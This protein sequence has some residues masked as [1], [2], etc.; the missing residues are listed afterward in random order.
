MIYTLDI[1]WLNITRYWTQFETKKAKTSFRLWIHKKTPHA[2][3]FRRNTWWRHQMEEFSASLALC[4]G[5]S[6]VTDE[7]SSQRPVTRSFDVFFDLPLNKRLSKHSWGWWFEAPSRSLCRHRCKVGCLF[8]IL[9]EGILRD[10]E[11]S[12]YSLR[13]KYQNRK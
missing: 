2:S 12:L 6:P 11:S 3:L 7:F 8:W 10:A 5:N 1:S 4:A 9:L 13:S